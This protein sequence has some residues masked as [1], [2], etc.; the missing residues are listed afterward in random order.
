[1]GYV[2]CLAL[3]EIEDMPEFVKAY[4]EQERRKALQRFAAALNDVFRNT[5]LIGLY[6]ENQFLVMMPETDA[7]ASVAP[8]IRFKKKLGALLFG[9][10]NRFIF[11]ISIGVS[12][13]PRD[14]R[15]VGGMLSLASAALRRSQQKG[16]GKG[17]ITLADSLFKKGGAGTA[18]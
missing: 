12:C 4:G 11:E 15:E 13:F 3:I 2:F 1:M 14:V 6:R 17:M 8:L 9:P 7:K 5:D 16:K 10:D 18:Q